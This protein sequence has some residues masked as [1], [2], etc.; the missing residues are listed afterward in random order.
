MCA[1]VIRVWISALLVLGPSSLAVR[2]ARAEDVAPSSEASRPPPAEDAEALIERA[3]G[4][5]LAGDEAGAGA[6]LDRAFLLRP[7]PV[8]LVEIAESEQRRGL[9]VEAFEHFSEAA[10]RPELDTKTRERVSDARR[11]L[12]AKV[13]RLDLRA[14]GLTVTVNGVAVPPSRLV[15]GAARV[16]VTPGEV[17]VVA[18][19]GERTWERHVVALAGTVSVV[20]FDEAF[21][22][23]RPPGNPPPVPRP[24]AAEMP[25][26]R[27]EQASFAP[28]VIF[29]VAGVIGLGVGIG[30]GSTAQSKLDEAIALS[31]RGPCVVRTSVA[32]REVADNLSAS[33]SFGVA[34]WVTYGVA[35]ASVLGAVA[36]AVI[37]RP[38][39]RQVVIGKALRPMPQITS[40]AAQ[41][42]LGGVF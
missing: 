26:V 22:V 33:R 25:P 34:A 20:T 14:S 19:L 11:E 9:S 37:T 24:S 38:W 40:D 30:L 10:L 42:A 5:R 1:R 16:A 21:G 6:L 7:T 8:L 12:E 13:A 18:K 4:L 3:H 15:D 17:L 36:W 27:F 28:S 41:F 2:V 39:E 32:C 31:A 23:A 35:G 29:G